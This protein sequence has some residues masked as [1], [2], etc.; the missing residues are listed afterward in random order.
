MVVV[1]ETVFEIKVPLIVAVSVI[2]D[3]ELVKGEVAIEVLVVGF[4][5]GNAEVAIVEV[6]D[7]A[8]LKA[9]VMV[10]VLVVGVVDVLKTPLYR[11]HLPCVRSRVDVMEI[12]F[13][14]LPHRKKELNAEIIAECDWRNCFPNAVP[15][16][17]ILPSINIIVA[18]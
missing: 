15:I 7:A 5:D 10:E 14:G 3:A 2:I 17:T 13:C 1:G 11:N 16:V 6:V 4:A 12:E 9:E 8:L 18:I